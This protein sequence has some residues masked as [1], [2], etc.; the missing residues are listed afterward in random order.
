MSTVI[1]K[2]FPTPEFCGKE[3][4][5][6]MGCG[7]PDG[8]TLDL[9]QN[10]VEETEKNICYK[11]CYALLP[12]ETN[13]NVCDFSVFK[14]ESA[15]LAKNL[16]G[17]EKVLLMAATIG[18]GIDRIIARYGR[19]SPAKAVMFQAI[20]SERVEALC[21]E[22]CKSYQQENKVIL[23]P[24]FSP[25]YGDLSIKVQKDIFAVLDCPRKI[26]ISLN[27]SFLMSPSKSV[28]AFVGIKENLER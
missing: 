14:T 8:A 13:G 16:E 6:Y 21:D 17:C 11:V 23:K 4:L 20:G 5:R 28:T 7:T 2:S 10:C 19:I 18:A 27:D 25:G 24:R 15:N 3:A 26:G 1:V 12:I 9:M 22:F